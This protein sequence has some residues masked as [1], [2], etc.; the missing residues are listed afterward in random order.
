MRGRDNLQSRWDVARTLWITAFLFSSSNKNQTNQ[1][2]AEKQGSRR[3][4]DR[5]RATIACYQDFLHRFGTIVGHY[6]YIGRVV[7]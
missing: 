7:T 2:G 4:R 6:G 5:D 3:F 1:T